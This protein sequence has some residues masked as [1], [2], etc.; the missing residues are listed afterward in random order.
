MTIEKMAVLAPMPRASVRI[1]TTVK[2]GARSRRLMRVAKILAKIVEGH[3]MS[4]LAPPEAVRKYCS[5]SEVKPHPPYVSW[6][7]E[8]DAVAVES[9]SERRRRRDHSR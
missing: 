8:A 6:R 5:S 9:S 1:V 3:V 7:S 4:S 2:A